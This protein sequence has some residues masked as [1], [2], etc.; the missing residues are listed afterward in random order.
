M[1]A[2]YVSK[3]TQFTL[4]EA[5]VQ[6]PHREEE[7][8][9]IYGRKEAKAEREREKRQHAIFYEVFSSLEE[10]PHT[11][12]LLQKVSEVFN[13]NYTEND[14][15]RLEWLILPHRSIESF[16]FSFILD[17]ELLDPFNEEIAELK[18]FLLTI[19]VTK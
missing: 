3:G 13:T 4:E 16:Y 17:C 11:Y 18:D 7:L 9:I 6:Y 1:K 14:K 12:R 2:D 5:I 15:N 10:K 19:G 8:K